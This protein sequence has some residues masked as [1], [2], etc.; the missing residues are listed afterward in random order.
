MIF[1]KKKFHNYPNTFFDNF[2]FFNNFHV[3]LFPNKFFHPLSKSLSL[4]LI[5]LNLFKYFLKNYS[6]E[7]GLDDEKRK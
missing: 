4:F 2:A 5:I 7:N 1:K 3:F 6:L